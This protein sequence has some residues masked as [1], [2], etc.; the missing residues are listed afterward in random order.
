MT[1]AAIYTMISRDEE[2]DG[3]A[4][5]RQERDCRALAKAKGWT[6]ADVL[7]DNDRSAYNGKARPGYDQ[8]LAGLRDGAYDALI[9]WKYDRLSR[10]GISG[11]TPL[12]EALDGRPLVCVNDSIDTSTPVGEGVAGLIASLAKQESK[13][14]SDRVKRKLDEVAEAGLPSG[15]GRKFGFTTAMKHNRREANL[16]REAVRRVLGGTSLSVIARDWD[17]RK[18]PQVNGGAGWTPRT[19]RCI[20]TSPRIA[21]LR[22]HRGDIVGMAAWKP[23]VARDD[24]EA[25]QLRLK[26]KAR[27][28]KRRSFLT[29]VVV[30]A[31]CGTPMLRDVDYGER[32]W[33]CRRRFNRPGCGKVSGPAEWLEKIVVDAL[34]TAVDG[35]GLARLLDRKD[36]GAGDELAAAE[37]TLRDLAEL[38]GA[39]GITQAEWLAARGAAER[40]AEAAR[41]RLADDTAS[42]ALAGFT[43]PGAL[44]AAWKKPLDIDRQ[45]AILTAVVEA[46]TVAASS[47]RGAR[48]DPGRIDMRWR[49]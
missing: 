44:R 30:C 23:I 8:L 45:R 5:K 19:L 31:E 38:L 29:G 26:T 9:A 7:T 41:R 33:R 16:V 49:A 10:T 12:L 34:L 25:M 15:G 21:G 13:N 43:A 4:V 17:R 40:R 2:D 3:K 11:L 20:L 6:V 18:V 37:R 46:V 47:G 48:L 36:T 28:P 42:R 1:R 32:V 35:P 24:F 27:E 22:V 14:I 39:G